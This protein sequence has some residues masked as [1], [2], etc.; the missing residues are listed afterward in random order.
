MFESFAQLFPAEW[1]GTITLLAAPLQWI[2]EW[3]AMV[4]RSAWLSYSPAATVS[5][6]VVL[7]LPVLLLIVGMWCTMLSLYTLPFRS[8][9]GGFLTAMLLAWWDALRCIWLYWAG[10]IRVGVALVGWVLGSLRFAL[11]F[12]KSCIVSLFRSPLT[13]LD[14][15]SRR[16]FQPGVPWIAFLVLVIWSAVEATVFTFTLQPTLNEVFS[17]LTGF[18]PRPIVM[19]PLLWLFLFML[20]GGSFACVQVL[21]EAV[22][23]RQVGTIIQMIVVEAAVMFFEVMFLYRE[24][25]DAITPWIAQQTGGELQ[26]GIV[27]TLGMASFGWVGVRGMSWFLFGRFGTPALLA[28]LGRQTITQD[29]G[30][31]FVEPPVQPDFWRGPIDALKKE[32]AWFHEEARRMFE[33]ISIPV[34]QLLA[35]ALNFAVV[36]MQ[37][38]PVFALPFSSID[39]MLV[40]TPFA[41]RG[42][43]TLGGGSGKVRAGGPIPGVAQ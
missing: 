41:T 27:A 22:A 34:M 37:S 9:R 13:L 33:L 38:R 12:V 16:Y 15:T 39:D 31:T 24:L 35:A 30:L 19:F 5:A 21:S 29:S 17:G 18:E 8:G 1:R 7:L 26:L 42:R 25:I 11:L 3:Q 6:A 28:I 10:M 32:T 43:D 14:W 23:T 2:P 40:A 4:L 36:V 20:I